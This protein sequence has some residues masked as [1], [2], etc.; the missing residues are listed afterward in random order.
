MTIK[1]FTK[2]IILI[3]KNFH[4]KYLID[5]QIRFIF[6]DVNIYFRL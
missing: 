4:F 3:Y 5:S 1:Q 6:R 2:I